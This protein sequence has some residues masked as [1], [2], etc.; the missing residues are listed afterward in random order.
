VP[1]DDR[2]LTESQELVAGLDSACRS[3]PAP[4]VVPLRA[5]KVALLLAAGRPRDL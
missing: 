5:F 2:N 1:E 3:G 4:E